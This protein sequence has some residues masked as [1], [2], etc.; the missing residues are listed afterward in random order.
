[1]SDT[2]THPPYGLLARIAVSKH[3]QKQGLG[4]KP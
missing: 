3:Y 2:D 4:K 1:M